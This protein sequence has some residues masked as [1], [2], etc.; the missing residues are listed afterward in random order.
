[1]PSVSLVIPAYN[2]QDALSG[3][4]ERCLKSL[5]ACTEDFEVIM[6]DD[7]SSDNTW[8]VMQSIAATDPQHIRALRHEQNRGIAATFEDLYKA[9]TKE[10]VFL[11]PGDGEY[12]PEALI[13]CMPLMEKGADIVICA[14]SNKNYTPYRQFV[15]DAYRYMTA[16]LFG[17][18][19]RDP[20]SIKC[21]RRTVMTGIPVR[22][23][24]VYVEVERILKA[25]RSGYRYAVITIDFEVRKGGK[26]RGARL[27]TVFA[28]A[29]DLVSLWWEMGRLQS[30]AAQVS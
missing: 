15:S 6:L 11:I 5:R 27:Q 14:R 2:E 20:G 22:C 19:L 3:T 23:K 28:A 16:L 18:D 13:R 7:A 12:P 4:V 25:L 10:F 1:M 29:K 17:V 26:A 21:V 9:A 24:S 30:H 8:G